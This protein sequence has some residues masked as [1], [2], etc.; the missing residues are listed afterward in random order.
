M[1][2]VITL[3]AV[4]CWGVNPLQVRG[5][6]RSG[7]VVV[8]MKD[9]VTSSGL[10]D[11]THKLMF[12]VSFYTADYDVIYPEGS[13]QDGAVTYVDKY[14]TAIDPEIVI[15]LKKTSSSAYY[16]QIRRSELFVD[17]KSVGFG[18]GRWLDPETRPL[19]EFLDIE[20]GWSLL[21]IPTLGAR[22]TL[23]QCKLAMPEIF[24]NLL[25]PPWRWGDGCYHLVGDEDE[26]AP[27]EG[28]WIY[29][30]EAQSIFLWCDFTE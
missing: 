17:G 18:N 16:K 24:S 4:G 26:L 27:L 7:E 8:V 23:G 20:P 5:E 21:S 13:Y 11:G 6:L 29:A 30:K 3:A 10:L 19:V 9:S 15:C 2:A 1:V 25:S 12:Q 14:V 22:L 28:Y